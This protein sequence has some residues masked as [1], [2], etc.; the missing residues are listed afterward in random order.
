MDGRPGR[1]G[2]VWPS[3]TPPDG[4]LQGRLRCRHRTRTLP[5]PRLLVF[6]WTGSPRSLDRT[7]DVLHAM[8]AP[9]FLCSTPPCAPHGRDCAF[10]PPRPRPNADGA[11]TTRGYRR[12]PLRWTIPPG[13]ALPGVDA[14]RCRAGPAEHPT[15]TPA[16]D[17]G[18]VH[19]AGCRGG[20]PR[21]VAAPLGATCGNWAL[22]TGRGQ[23]L[24]PLA[25]RDARSP[26]PTA[27][28]SARLLA[29]DGIPPGD[30]GG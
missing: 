22:P 17:P 18:N 19:A 30:P 4:E 7:R 2:P 28:G 12:A 13:S 23:P 14:H 25:G 20:G 11:R 1:P 27:G 26:G 3:D 16:L 21:A 5:R 24:A 15:C 6:L 29:R 8:G 9:P 10:S